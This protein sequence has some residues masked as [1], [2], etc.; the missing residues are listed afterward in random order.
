M[1]AKIAIKQLRH[2][3]GK[4][5]ATIRVQPDPDQMREAKREVEEYQ[6]FSWNDDLILEAIKLGQDKRNLA[7]GDPK[8]QAEFS[9]KSAHFRRKFEFRRDRC[10]LLWKSLMMDPD[11][12][13]WFHP[14]PEPWSV[15]A[16]I[17]ALANSVA[18]KWEDNIGLSLVLDK[19]TPDDLTVMAYLEQIPVMFEHSRREAES[20]CILVA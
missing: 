20:S 12:R 6:E 11:Q 5:E 13:R 16:E 3:I 18:R 9:L 14:V 2:R 1:R 8:L 15:D 7:M 4:L 17:Q 19:L 10:P